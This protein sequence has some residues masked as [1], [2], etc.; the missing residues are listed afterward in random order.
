MNDQKPLQFQAGA[1]DYFIYTIVTIVLVYI[2]IFG[3]AYLL[4]YSG[5]WF[6]KRA[7]VT[8]KNVEFNAGYLESLK[9]V[10]INVL[11]LIV[12]LGIYSFWFYPK[13]YR[14]V[15]DHVAFAGEVAA[16][17]EATPVGPV[18][19][20]PV[21]PQAPIAPE[22]PVAPSAPVAP[23]NVITPQAAGP[24]EPINPQV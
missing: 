6:S 18:F 14:Y 3:W 24:T 13:M 22:S 4:N 7:L 12:T 17:V 20:T 21:Q 9:F 2:P 1:L 23:E 19:E 15:A 10:F 11:L 16:P 8:G 5:S